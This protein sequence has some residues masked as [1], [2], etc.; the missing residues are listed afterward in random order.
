MDNIG[1]AGADYILETPSDHLEKTTDTVDDTNSTHDLD[2]I[3][4]EGADNISETPCDDLQKTTDTVDITNSTHDLDTNIRLEGADNISETP[5][6]DLEKQ[7]IQLTLQIPPMIWII[8]D[9]REQTTF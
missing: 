8:S 6:D 3:G 4:L 9:L 5:C 7:Q 1:L 2:N